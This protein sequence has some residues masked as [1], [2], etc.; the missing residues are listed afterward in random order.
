MPILGALLVTL[1]S[2]LADFLVRYVTGKVAIGLAAA[3][4][5]GGIIGVLLVAMRTVINPL[6]SA[7]FS[8]S[9]GNFISLA[10]PPIASTCI[11]AYIAAWSACTLYAWQKK[12]LDLYVQA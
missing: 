1:A 12:C 5:L 4:T 9:Y 3:I 2:G 7:M 11:T 6:V 8:T 10:F